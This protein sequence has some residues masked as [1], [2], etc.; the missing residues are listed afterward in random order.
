MLKLDEKFEGHLLVS[1]EI[2]TKQDLGGKESR[3]IKKLL[4]ALRH[5]F[6]NNTF[7][8][9]KNKTTCDFNILF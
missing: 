8:H 6:R 5:L 7:S 9:N 2:E 3:R 1:T 4:G